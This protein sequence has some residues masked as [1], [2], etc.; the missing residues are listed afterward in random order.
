MQYCI[1]SKILT[2]W[3]KNV[4]NHNKESIYLPWLPD[5]PNDSGIIRDSNCALFIRDSFL[6]VMPSIVA[7]F[8]RAGYC[9]GPN[10]YS[11]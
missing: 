8:T 4:N 5:Q 9:A 11:R 10:M 7:K 6:S 2:Q 3:D 1:T